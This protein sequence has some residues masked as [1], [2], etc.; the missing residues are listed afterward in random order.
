MSAPTLDATATDTTTSRVADDNPDATVK[1]HHGQHVEK[2]IV[3]DRSPDEVYAFW[4]NF[5]NLPIFMTHLK[6]VTEIGPGRT[7]WVAKGPAGTTQEWD[8]EVINEVTDQLIA[9]HSVA[10]A[11]VH[12]AGSVRFEPTGTGNATNVTVELEY[13]PPAGALGVAV[14]WLFGEE[15]SQ[16]IDDD[17]KH[18]KNYLESGE[19]PNN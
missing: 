17:L 8:A 5:T 7:H 18:L 11:D 15:P 1:H 19:N 14:A 16:Q 13:Q 2:S 4:R 9:W 10:D 3:V 6:S 12:N